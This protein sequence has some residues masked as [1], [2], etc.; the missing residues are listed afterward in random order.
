M[1]KAFHKFSLLILGLFLGLAANTQ[2]KTT[3]PLHPEVKSGV[4]DNGMHYY[5]LHTKS[6]SIKEIQL[7]KKEI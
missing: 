2:V 7:L 4:L 6:K 5:I 3:F 1:M